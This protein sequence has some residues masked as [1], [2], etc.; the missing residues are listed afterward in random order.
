MAGFLFVT[1][2]ESEK[3][4]DLMEGISLILLYISFVVVQFYIISAVKI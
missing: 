2:I 3:K 4:L 1:F